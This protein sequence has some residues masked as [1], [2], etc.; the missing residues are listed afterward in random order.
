M[1]INNNSVKGIF[2]YSAELRELYEVGDL[3][4][5]EDKL[6]K[7]KSTVNIVS[8]DPESDLDNKCFIE[9][10][11]NLSITDPD[12]LIED[13]TNK[14]LFLSSNLIESVFN[15]YL[16][17]LKLN[18]VVEEID[19]GSNFNDFKTSRVGVISIAFNIED[20]S[21]LPS[22]G[23]FDY[24]YPMLLVRVYEISSIVL[25]NP[26]IVQE[27]IDCKSG[28]LYVRVYDSGI[29]SD[30][31]VNNGST[32]DANQIALNTNVNNLTNLLTSINNLLS[33]YNQYYSFFR[34]TNS[35]LTYSLP[36]I[37]TSEDPNGEQLSL[38]NAISSG[39]SI[40]SESVLL[41][42]IIYY[43]R[44]GVRTQYIATLSIPESG[45]ISTNDGVVGISY[46][47]SD[48]SIIISSVWQLTELSLYHIIGS[49]KINFI[50]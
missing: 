3:V 10:T 5:K 27:I 29:W 49:P 38:N 2:I 17:G 45:T 36:Q 12:Q 24:S 9:Y 11:R 16:A 20:F 23:T 19:K 47:A 40:I 35:S 1:L 14:K 43:T 21:N 42:F 4:V 6:Y 32:W 33:N 30:W 44:N 7:V 48:R 31:V 26:K 13:N 41:K 28:F 15:K 34:L 46:S 39:N 8:T 25:P 18:G 22:L 37:A 50:S